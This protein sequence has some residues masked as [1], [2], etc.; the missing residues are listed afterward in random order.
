MR[1]EARS[2]ERMIVGAILVISGLAF[3]NALDGQFVYDDRLQILKNPTLN[4]LSNIPKMFTQGVW[5]F[6]NVSDVSAPGPYYRPIFNIVL[7]I[8][9]HLFG[10]E[11][12]GWH[13]VSIAL[14]LCVVFLV[15]RLAR[16]WGL[17]FEVAAASALLF[18][19]HPVHS[20][21]VAWVSAIPDPLAAVFI[22]SS[23]LLYERYYYSA[24]IRKPVDRYAS[25]VLAL[26]AMAS[27]EVAVIYPVFLVAREMLGRP[28][29]N[30]SELATRLLKRTAPFFGAVVV[31]LLMR[32]YVLGFLR[33]DEPKS[34]GIPFFRVLITIPSVLFSYVRMLVAPYP[35]AVF[36]DN[37]YVE[38]MTDARFWAAALVITALAIAIWWAVRKNAPALLAAAF[39][40]IFI[41]PTLNL[42][43]FR[44][45]ESLLHD[46]YLYLSSIG[47]CILVAMG[48]DWLSAAF[49]QRR[50]VFVGA[51]AVASVVLLFLT[52]YQNYSWQNEFTM[53]DYALRVAPRWPFTQNYIGAYQAE[54]RRFPE[55]ERA[56]RA[57]LDIDPNYYDSL[58]NLGDIY[59][60]EGHLREA[61]KY[62]LDAI[63]DGAPYAETHYN[64]AVSYVAEN[65]L[66]EAE[67]PLKEALA[68]RPAHVKARYNLGWLYDQ[69]GRADL[70]EQEY[71]KTLEYDPSYPE[72]RI[73][74]GVLLTKQQR[75]D[76]ALNQ[77]LT[78]QRYAPDHTVMLYALGDV[79]LKTGRYDDAIKVFKQLDL[80]NLH[81]NLIHTSMGMCYE[82]LGRRD[83]AKTE[84][85]KAIDVASQDQYTRVAREH[86]A[87][88]QGG[89]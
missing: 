29:E 86:L 28:R 47:F 73:N 64:L 38:S 55:A 39:M 1:T 67:Q 46:R 33:Q 18:G 52:F 2:R 10:L 54:Q 49:S 13:L 16:K 75:Y 80:R 24:G 62:Y 22:L 58:S 26:L 89:G 12:T 7:I 15:Y 77:L 34:I 32:Y 45:E 50:R 17:T 25:V 42:K 82:N 61:E 85:Q 36:Y 63:A 70:A 9:R 84:F 72:P 69:Q 76:Q 3:A 68:I 88:L 14:H 27:K 78:A 51:T 23:L 83:E 65:R 35:L 30:Y 37:R 20:E 74:L 21:S 31:Y 11:V 5:Q 59:R 66:A 57:A 8:N 48:F 44:S 6:L 4:S 71:T 40:I 87:K 81:Q 56:Y 79:Y 41:L 53:T 19:L 43:A 60:E